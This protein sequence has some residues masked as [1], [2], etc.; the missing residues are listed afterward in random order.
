M[1]KKL[2][3]KRTTISCKTSTKKKLRTFELHKRESDNDIILRLME[4][5]K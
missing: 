3:D 1:N 2:E 5:T 4:K